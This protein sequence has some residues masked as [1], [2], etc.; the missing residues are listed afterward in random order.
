M[1]V[2]WRNKLSEIRFNQFRKTSIL[3]F[4]VV[5]RLLDYRIVQFQCQFSVHDDYLYV[6]KYLLV[7]KIQHFHYQLA[8]KYSWNRYKNFDENSL[9]RRNQ[10]RIVVEA[11]PK[12]IAGNMLKRDSGDALQ[13]NYL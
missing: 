4:R 13:N 11:V 2:I 8:C 6:Q 9:L 7:R 3:F 10:A 12:R 1:L 5:L